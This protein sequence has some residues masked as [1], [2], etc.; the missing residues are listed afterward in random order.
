MPKRWAIIEINLDSPTYEHAHLHVI[1]VPEFNEPGFYRQVSSFDAF[2]MGTQ[3][4]NWNH[5]AKRLYAAKRW[6]ATGNGWDE[7]NGECDRWLESSKRYG[8][9]E[10][11]SR[12]LPRTD[13]P[14]VWSFYSAV[15]Y[16]YKKKRYT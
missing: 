4:H 3:Q 5:N 9:Q 15:G 10:M 14:D 1:A 7:F 8:I 13:Y 2:F 12:N 11:D 16:D 6:G